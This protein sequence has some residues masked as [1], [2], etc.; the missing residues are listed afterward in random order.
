MVKKIIIGLVLLVM[1]QGV[2]AQ[3]TDH[4]LW[5]GASFGLKIN[6][7][8]SASIEEQFRINQ[9]ISNLKQALTEL[10]VKYKLG[11]HFALKGYYRFVGKPQKNNKNRLA[12]DL[13]ANYKLKSIPLRFSYRLRLQNTVTANSGNTKKYIRNKFG[14]SYNLSKLVDPFVSYE[15]YYRRAKSEF[16][17]T[18]LTLGLD[19]RLNK[20]M[21]LTTYYRIQNYI[22][23][24]NLRQRN[25]IGVMFAY[26]TSVKKLKKKKGSSSI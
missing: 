18:R 5:T 12:I 9:N 1:T 23:V 2:A 10:G 26:S 7:K 15:L 16:R 8:W 13:L 20:R 22:N 4:E 3:S 24:K 6:K 19:W 17:V 25:I 11:K 21:S 14:L